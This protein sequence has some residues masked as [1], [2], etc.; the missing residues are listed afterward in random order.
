MAAASAAVNGN[1][2]TSAST[3]L[4]AGTVKGRR[5]R[6]EDPT[7]PPSRSRDMQR[8]FR[9][10]RAAH[11]ANLEARVE[12]LE[13]ENNELRSRLGMP[14]RPPTPS[15]DL[16]IDARDALGG[17][18][19]RG[20]EDDDNSIAV[21][22][23]FEPAPP[24]QSHPVATDAQTQH[25]NTASPSVLDE[26]RSSEAPS[27]FPTPTV[28]PGLPSWPAQQAPPSCPDSN[29]HTLQQ[30]SS[31]A[32]Y[33]GALPSLSSLQAQG[34][35][36][37]SAHS[38]VP[39]PATLPQNYNY[40]VQLAPM[41]ASDFSS[42]AMPTTYQQVKFIS[43]APIQ[44]PSPAPTAYNPSPVYEHASVPPAAG[45]WTSN[46]QLD[47]MPCNPTSNCCP[48]PSTSQPVSQQQ[49]L[50][51]NPTPPSSVNSGGPSS[52]SRTGLSLQIPY[53]T[54]SVAS[55][56]LS[57]SAGA[58][59]LERQAAP[60]VMS[61]TGRTLPPRA[62]P[63]SPRTTSR[64]LQDYCFV[65]PSV[66]ASTRTDASSAIYVKFLIQLLQGLEVTGKG[67]L[68]RLSYT[69][70][71]ERQLSE[72]CGGLVDCSGP[73]FDQVTGI[74]SSKASFED[75]DAVLEQG[76]TPVHEAWQVLREA[77]YGATAGLSSGS[78]PSS[79]VAE[80]RQ[81]TVSLNGGG[82][83]ASVPSP[84]AIVAEHFMYP[85]AANNVTQVPS[86]QAFVTAHNANFVV[87]EPM[88]LSASAL[89]NMILDHGTPPSQS[90]TH[91]DSSTLLNNPISTPY[92]VAAR[93]SPN[94]K[95]LPGF[96]LVI[97]SET[98][99]HLKKSWDDVKTICGNGIVPAGWT[100]PGTDGQGNRKCCGPP[101]LV[102]V[103]L[104]SVV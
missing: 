37:T 83:G 41:Y 27:P 54:S 12:R 68:Q 80:Q 95:V 51:H 21:E 17:A 47:M 57:I 9:A 39:T 4:K 77:C 66:L 6:K 24:A 81:R 38:D 5:G 18:G 86:N 1:A 10:R 29:E 32:S 3:K 36:T 85:P 64:L 60:Q 103:K 71:E 58:S 62:P 82:S 78:T 92:V 35:P 11:L 20:D 15:D 13:R 40:P 97:K 31:S 16:S 99:Q 61:S 49:P 19:G 72:C 98:V 89:A 87:D 2:S 46:R 56:S 93:V 102:K 90:S 59:P 34:W 84:T 28:L 33:S 67:P 42:S 70:E 22:T 25:V 100:G 79:P 30:H 88:G 63:P 14:P 91:S 48:M 74:D 23:V 96:G 53:H 43:Q 94:V 8:A 101:S 75:S 104:E 76:W 73:L 50:H 65:P 7:L 26:R 52:A 44:T 69:H 55:P 45:A